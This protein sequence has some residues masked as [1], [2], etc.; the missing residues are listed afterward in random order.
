MSLP[1]LPF[2]PISLTE[3]SNNPAPTQT[4]QE[5]VQKMINSMM[6]AQ[7]PIPQFSDFATTPNVN[8]PWQQQEVEITSEEQ[9]EDDNT[10]QSDLAE[11]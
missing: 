5:V 3:T 10:N 2:I 11:R 4:D 8:N 9:E 1:S 7:G 6:S